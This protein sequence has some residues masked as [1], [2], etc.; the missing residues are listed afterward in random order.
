LK[1][2]P[3]RGALLEALTY[4][5]ESQLASGA[6]ENH[7]PTLVFI[8]LGRRNCNEHLYIIEQWQLADR[9]KILIRLADKSVFKTSPVA[10]RTFFKFPTS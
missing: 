5:P 9:F 1:A 2:A 10:W 8:K 6:I 3:I 4:T 7:Q